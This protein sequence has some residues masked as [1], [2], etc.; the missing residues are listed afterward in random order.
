[1]LR[2]AVARRVKKW[3]EAST[4]MV[5][6]ITLNHD[7]DDAPR[8][9]EPATVVVMRLAVPLSIALLSVVSGCSLL[10]TTAPID[11]G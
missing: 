6:R 4:E 3:A 2:R 8:L 7:D 11:G 5:R 9:S 1:M 10:A